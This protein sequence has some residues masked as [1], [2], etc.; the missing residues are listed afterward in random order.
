MPYSPTTA[1]PHPLANIQNSD[2]NSSF[3]NKLS[4]A[5]IEQ[6]TWYGLGDLVNNFRESSLGLRPIN[7]AWAPG[8]MTRLKIPF[9][10][11]WYGPL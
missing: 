3:T 9:T 2:F 6:V 1:F 11:C 4:F 8:L 10:Y 7:L 5:L